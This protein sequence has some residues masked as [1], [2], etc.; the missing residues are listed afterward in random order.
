MLKESL[1]SFI[2]Q[3]GDFEIIVGND[4]GV[5]IKNI[6]V[7]KRIRYYKHK[8]RGIAATCNLVRRYATGK[9]IMP[10]AD[11]DISLPGHIKILSDYLDIHNDIDAVYGDYIIFNGRTEEYATSFTPINIKE[12]YERMKKFQVYP[13]GG[14]MWR[15]EKY[16]RLDETLES[17]I[18]WELMFNCL[19]N[20]VRFAKVPITLWKFR[21]GHKHEEGTERQHEGCR[22]IL[23][24]RGV[25]YKRKEKYA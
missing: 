5:D 25:K 22:I 1:E 6:V 4:G 9:Y 18:D 15:R 11:D 24:R 3:E 19:E 17:A 2:H 12:D 7:D 13:H 21:T 20:G 8:H 23:A 10:F 14:T 16:P